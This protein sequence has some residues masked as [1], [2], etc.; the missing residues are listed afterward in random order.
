[1]VCEFAPRIKFLRKKVVCEHYRA[2]SATC[3]K[4]GPVNPF[5]GEIYCGAYRE[6]ISQRK[7]ALVEA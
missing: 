2:D 1:M 4:D 6:L 7:P 5:T 3:T